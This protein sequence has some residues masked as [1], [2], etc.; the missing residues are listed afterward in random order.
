MYSGCS[1][2]AQQ[3]LS[4]IVYIGSSINVLDYIVK[5]IIFVGR[6]FYNLCYNS[7]KPSVSTELIVII[8]VEVRLSGL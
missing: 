4:L 5:T 2:S 6:Y 8:F 1:V 3:T 7:N